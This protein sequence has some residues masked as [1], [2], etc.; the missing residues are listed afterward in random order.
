MGI[1][2]GKTKTK[3]TKS[4]GGKIVSAGKSLLSG[5]SSKGGGR[6]RSRLTPEKLAKQI[7]V[8]KLKRKLWKL[9]YGGR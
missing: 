4:I 3:K 1:K 6:R 7:L 9:K 8:L 2:K 5:K